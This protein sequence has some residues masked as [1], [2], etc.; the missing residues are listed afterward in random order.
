[1]F[2]CKLECPRCHKVW[3]LPQGSDGIYCDC[4][5][6]C[7]YGEKPSDCNLTEQNYNGPLNWPVGLDLGQEDEGSD[8]LHRTYYCSTH[9]VYSYKAPIYLEVDWEKWRQMR[10]LPQRLRELESR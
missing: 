8:V 1:M 9:A 7:Q 5:L 4:H 2:E 3:T 6:W 10:K